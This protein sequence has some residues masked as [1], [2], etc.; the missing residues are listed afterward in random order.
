[1]IIPGGRFLT[2]SDS[3]IVTGGTGQ[4][5]GATGSFADSGGGT[6]TGTAAIQDYTFSGTLTAPGLIAAPEPGTL[7]LFSTGAVGL[8]L[9]LRRRMREDRM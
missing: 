6:S 5:A 3:Y 9:R 7:A 4:F 8:A 2:T 1:M